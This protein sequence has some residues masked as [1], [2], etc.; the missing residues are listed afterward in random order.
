MMGLEN[1]TRNNTLSCGFVVAGVGG[2]RPGTR[3]SRSFDWAGPIVVQWDGPFARCSSGL[4]MAR[5]KCP[6]LSTVRARVNRKLLID[7]VYTPPPMWTNLWK[8]WIAMK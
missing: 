8:L 6:A 7:C 3:M 2:V 1:V 5:R 4:S